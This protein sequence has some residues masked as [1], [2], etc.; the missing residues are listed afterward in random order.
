MNRSRL[1]AIA[2]LL[3]SAPAAADEIT[4]PQVVMPNVL[5]TQTGGL[6][7]ARLDYTSFDNIDATFLGF[8]VW[9]QYITPGG[10]GA[11]V[12]LPYSYVSADEDVGD[13]DSVSGLGNIELGGLLVVPNSPSLD[14]YARAGLTLDTVEDDVTAVL[15]LLATVP[16]R[17]GEAFTGYGADALRAH[18]GFRTRGPVAVGGEIG[19]DIPLDDLDIDAILVASGSV[20]ITQGK[21]GLSG[22][23]TYL[24]GIGGDD[25][26]DIVNLNITA[27][28]LVAPKV[29]LFGALGITLDGFEG[30]VDETPFSL[31]AGLRL[32]I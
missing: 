7:D 10:L 19:F 4:P 11:Y 9:A 14:L 23:L 26:E 32:G 5:S 2:S 13:D 17:P 6:L 27:D 20:G 30:L 24:T 21:L 8:N 16:P 22:G 31:G 28:V 29:R 3:V 15:G 18:G 12:Q 1:A 25:G